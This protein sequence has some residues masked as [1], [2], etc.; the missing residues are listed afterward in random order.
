MTDIS[1]FDQ[2][3]EEDK[4]VNRII[5]AIELYSKVYNNPLLINATMILFLNKMDLLEKKLLHSR[6]IEV[7][8]GYKGAKF[9]LGP[10]EK[11]AVCNFFISYFKAQ[12]QKNRQSP[13]IH[14]TCCLDTQ[15]MGVLMFGV[16]Y[17]LFNLDKV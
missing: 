16:M 3:L 10:Q 7:F 12:K 2:T 8:P 9:N 14:K 4:R 17:T 5:D 13:V 15:A 1:S 11:N 6:V